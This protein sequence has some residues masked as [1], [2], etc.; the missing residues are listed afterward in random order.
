M[1]TSLPAAAQQ[2]LQN[3][4]LGVARTDLAKRA[5][6]LSEGYRS[7]GSSAAVITSELDALAYA[8]VRMPATYAAVQTV[9]AEAAAR[10]P[11][12]APASI[13]DLG[14][15][16]GTATLAA[17]QTWPGS[18]KSAVMVEPNTHLGRYAVLMAAAGDVAAARLSQ[19]AT[20]FAAPPSDMVV[21][22]YI[23]VEMNA[24]AA[25]RVVKTAL[26][27]ARDMIVLIE[28][29]TTAGFARIRRAREMLVAA[30]WH[31]AAPCPHHGA[32]PLLDGDW[33][34][35]SVRLARSKDHKLVKGADAPFEDEPYSYVIATR[36]GVPKAPARILRDP[37]VHK[38][39]VAMALCTTGGL[40]TRVVGVRDPSF[41]AARKASAGDAWDLSR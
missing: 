37:E 34:H 1:T 3:R 28:P 11:D 25:D 26:A 6:A 21:A 8:V 41:K 40:E 5:Q 9:M 2:V 7:G 13:L 18:L 33:C 38:A 4:L 12:M 35:F 16:P 36:I 31:L 24:A 14:A 15:G 20:T 30:G 22:S 32:C 19:D 17:A 27:A 23:L 29:G 10:A 39:T